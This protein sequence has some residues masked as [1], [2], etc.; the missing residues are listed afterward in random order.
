[1]QQLSLS[2]RPRSLDALVG[3]EKV[4]QRIRGHVKNGRV[5]KAWLLVGPTGTGKTTLARILSLS[6]QCEHQTVFGSPC[7]ACY[8]NKSSFDIFETNASKHTGKDEIEAAL[9]GADSYPRMGAYRVYIIDEVHR[10]SANAQDMIL[11]YLEDTPETTIF[12]L[13]STAPHRLIE[14][15]QGRCAGGLLRL[16]PLDIDGVTVLVARL[17]KRIKSK[18]PTDRLAE[19]LVE[20]GVFYPRHITHAVDRYAAGEM[21]EEAAKVLAGEAIDVR[22]LTRAVVKGD[23]LGV[24]KYMYAAESSDARAIRLGCLAYLRAI[25][26]QSSEI[27]DRTAAVAF[28]IKELCGLQNSEDSVIMSGVSAALY[29]ITGVLSE[30]RH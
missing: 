2:A 16:R 8:E 14:T 13:C 28:A 26:L 9:A 27:S 22:A 1:M 3:Q 17:L 23:W 15:L 4:V 20:A 5:V 30:Y 19:A 6:F 10:A 12:I 29:T 7:K 18:L 11:K 24:A 21:P 25:L